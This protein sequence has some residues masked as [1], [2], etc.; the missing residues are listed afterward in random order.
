[1]TQLFRSLAAFLLLF[2]LTRAA[3]AQ[4]PE[5]PPDVPTMTTD[6]A[7][8]HIPRPPESFVR[9]EVDGWLNVAYDAAAAPRLESV[10]KHATEI[11]DH[12]AHSLGQPLSGRVELRVTRSFEDMAA[13]APD[14]AP[15][16][17]YAVAVAYP[18]LHY[19]MLSLSPPTMQ[20][21]TPDV[22]KSFEHELSHIA[23]FDAV[24]G[25]H[26]PLWFNEGLAMWNAH[27]T[28]SHVSTM[29]QASFAKTFMPFSDLDRS[30]PADRASIAYAQSADFM[31]FLMRRT[32]EGRF[33]SLVARVK[34]GDNFY[35]SMTDA[36][37][38]DFRKLEYQ[39]REDVAQ[40][41]PFWTTL[42]AGGSIVWVFGSIAI[43]VAFVKRRR[44][45]K[46]ILARWE[47]EEE[48]EDRVVAAAAED[49]P[50]MP[51]KVPRVEHEGEWYTLH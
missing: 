50:P 30:F 23:L 44:R 25:K 36:Y 2:F 6:G 21:E 51:T 7:R 34:T 46:A 32:D 16:P 10:L 37:G 38:S 39:W 18:G 45:S 26:V 3:S 29:S 31:R 24:A 33:R 15:P 35:A 47:K 28:W 20:A 43:V 5:L 11:R 22:E 1:M 14:G 49:P 41:Y 19:M 48:F 17:A 4:T 8:T 9:R 13:L 42:F 40:R 27:E 12:L